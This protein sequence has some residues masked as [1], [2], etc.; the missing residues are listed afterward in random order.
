M[1]WVQLDALGGTCCKLHVT[2]SLII[3]E[4]LA[5]IVIQGK[6]RVA[7]KEADT[8]PVART[9]GERVDTPLDSYRQNLNVAVDR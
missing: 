2:F 8:T 5:Y 9:A 7:T 4:L 1:N 3:V 6:T